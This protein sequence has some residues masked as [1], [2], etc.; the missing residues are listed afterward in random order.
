MKNVPPAGFF[1]K[2]V[3]EQLELSLNG[4]T[5]SEESCVAALLF[6]RKLTTTSVTE[7]CF[8]K[9]IFTSFF[10]TLEV[11]VLSTGGGWMQ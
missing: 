1:S 10:P 5:G 9:I 4:A 2:P 7:F 8:Y 6:D 11:R 3:A